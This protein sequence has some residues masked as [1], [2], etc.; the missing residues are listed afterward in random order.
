MDTFLTI[1]FWIVQGAMAGLGVFV[2]LKSQPKE[3]HARFIVAFIILFVIGGAINTVQTIRNGSAQDALKQGI[4]DLRDGQTQS[5]SGIAKMSSDVAQL[6]KNTHQ[7]P[8]VTVSL[9]V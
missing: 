5:N 3:K 7:P 8:N 1:A 6:E 2:S 9:P 4:Q